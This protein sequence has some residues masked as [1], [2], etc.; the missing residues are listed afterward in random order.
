MRTHTLIQG[1]GFPWVLVWVALENP[2]V[3]P[4]IPYVQGSYPLISVIYD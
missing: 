4:H 3:A 1:Y 2:R